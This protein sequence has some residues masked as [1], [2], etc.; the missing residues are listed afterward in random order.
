MLRAQVEKIK[1]YK[2][3]KNY[4]QMCL[5]GKDYK[6]FLSWGFH[7]KYDEDTVMNFTSQQNMY[8]LFTENERNSSLDNG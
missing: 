6:D 5:A 7:L 1:N 4:S 3:I 2:Q 8:L